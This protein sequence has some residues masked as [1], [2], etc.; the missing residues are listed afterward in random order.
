MCLTSVKLKQNS[1]RIVLAVQRTE[2]LVV[3]RTSDCHADEITGMGKHDERKGRHRKGLG[4]ARMWS[5]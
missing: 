5:V 2:K 3:N 4:V 1:I